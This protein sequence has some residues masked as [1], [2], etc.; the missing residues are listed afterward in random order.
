MSSD[1][2]DP[3]QRKFCGF[4]ASHAPGPSERQLGE[5]WFEGLGTENRLSSAHKIDRPRTAGWLGYQKRM[6]IQ[7]WDLEVGAL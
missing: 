6:E 4:T 1:H 5:A 7:G 3:K 2:E